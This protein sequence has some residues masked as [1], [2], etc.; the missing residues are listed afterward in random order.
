[1]QTEITIE[2]AARAAQ[3]ARQTAIM[4][5]QGRP[6]S[7]YFTVA[8]CRGTKELLS[9]MPWIAD[10]HALSCLNMA[11]QNMIPSLSIGCMPAC[12]RYCPL[13][14]LLIVL[15]QVIQ[16]QLLK[17]NQLF[18]RYGR[19]SAL[20]QIMAACCIVCCKDSASSWLAS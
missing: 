13:L 8:F 20:R 2:H 4:V 5:M 17:L 11:P 19:H 16:R 14:L 7:K 6:K 18:P 9:W 15:K 3:F 10:H 12:Q 1:M